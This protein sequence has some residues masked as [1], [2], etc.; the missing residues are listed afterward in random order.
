MFSAGSLGSLV[1]S[2]REFGL[3]LFFSGLSG[4]KGGVAGHLMIGEGSM[5]AV[6]WVQ[7]CV[8]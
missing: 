5:I 2:G 3:A 1:S 4:V 7:S 8:M 6:F